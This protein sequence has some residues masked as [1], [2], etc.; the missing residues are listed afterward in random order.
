MDMGTDMRLAMRVRVRAP[1]RIAWGSDVVLS[2]REICTAR[3]R[4]GSLVRQ[5]LMDE[6]AGERM[7]SDRLGRGRERARERGR[8]MQAI[9]TAVRLEHPRVSGAGDLGGKP[10]GRRDSE[11]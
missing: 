11:G 1:L 4:L 3:S 8:G 7:D 9:G 6:E 10:L 5:D 2:Y